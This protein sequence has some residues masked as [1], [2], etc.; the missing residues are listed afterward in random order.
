VPGQQA[1]REFGVHA[2]LSFQVGSGISSAV[3]AWP[4]G[5]LLTLSTNSLV[6]VGLDWPIPTQQLG[7]TGLLALGSGSEITTPSVLAL[8]RLDRGEAS[9]VVLT[10]HGLE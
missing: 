5:P 7:G 9:G 8:E 3:N 6:P 1:A 10:A 4:H 2:V